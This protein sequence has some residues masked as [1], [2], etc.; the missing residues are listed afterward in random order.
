MKKKHNNYENLPLA[1]IAKSKK[2][3]KNAI[4][5]SLNMFFDVFYWLYKVVMLL[6]RDVM[7][8]DDFCARL[9][10]Y[11]CILCVP[12]DPQIDGHKVH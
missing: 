4:P 1:T 5:E 10:R 9:L 12:T 6:R 3:L 2:I 11:L 8:T 7:K